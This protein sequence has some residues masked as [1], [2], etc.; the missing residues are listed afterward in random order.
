MQLLQSAC[1]S[2]RERLGICSQRVSLT[3]EKFNTVYTSNF[4]SIV[5]ECFVF[6]FIVSLKEFEYFNYYGYPDMGITTKNTSCVNAYTCKYE[7][8]PF[9]IFHHDYE[10]KAFTDNNM[11]FITYSSIGVIHSNKK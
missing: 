6:K 8:Y 4:F 5:Q 1:S 3:S 10:V 2:L 9:S 11:D 7:G